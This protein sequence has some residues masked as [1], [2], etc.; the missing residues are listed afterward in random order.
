LSGIKSFA[1]FTCSSIKSITIPRH[2]QIFCS[3]CFHDCRSLPSISFQVESELTR[4]EDNA[5][6]GTSLT[7]VVIPGSTS[8]IAGTAFPDN[9]ITVTAQM[10]RR[11]SNL[12][13]S[14]PIPILSTCE[15]LRSFRKEKIVLGNRHESDR[16]FS[17]PSAQRISYEET[18]VHGAFSPRRE[19]V[20]RGIEIPKLVEARVVPQ[21][22]LT[23]PK[24][25]WPRNNVGS[26]LS[27]TKRS[28]SIV[29]DGR[30]LTNVRQ[31][32]GPVVR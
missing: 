20:D 21:N 14:D 32:H 24:R 19:G 30:F 3:E 27:P 13:R 12:F 5:F 7:S 15:K 29:R 25:V 26:E 22:G 11:Y 2:V 8:F 23:E 10:R 9:C 31:F 1:F 28:A 6:K 4:I 17:T 18:V 16:C